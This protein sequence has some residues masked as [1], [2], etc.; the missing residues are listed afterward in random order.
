MTAPRPGTP[1]ATRSCPHCA[2]TI[3]ESA[4]VCPACR[5]HLR[6]DPAGSVAPPTAAFSPLR[7]EGS[8]R[9]PA[10]SD[11]WEYSM[12]LAIRNERGDEVARRI[13]GVGAMQPDE[14]RSFTLTVEVAPATGKGSARRGARH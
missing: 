5:H 3:L 7:V 11:V 14:Q 13:V 2:E 4:A 6:Y 9:N 12:V 1:G 8:I 10:D